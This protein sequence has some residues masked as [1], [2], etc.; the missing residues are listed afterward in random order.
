MKLLRDMSWVLTFTVFWLVFGDCTEMEAEPAAPEQEVNVQ[1]RWAFGAVVGA[2]DARQFVAIRRDTTLQTG[3]ELKMLV[4]VQRPCFVYVV[5]RSS[6]GEVHLLFPGEAEEAASGS[7][8]SITYYVPEGEA[9]FKLDDRVGRETF[10]LLASAE[11]LSDL[12]ILID[13]YKSAESSGRPEMASRIVER[14]RALRK[15]HRKLAT[16]AERPVSIAGNVRSTG[17]EDKSWLDR[18]SVEISAKDFY[19]KAFTI[20]HRE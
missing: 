20:D 15:A 18:I 2:E 13:D 16:A 5:Y 7:E 9:R 6:R 11:R 4:D 14:I 10:Y 17:P 12:E 1:F 8:T 19:S 3:D